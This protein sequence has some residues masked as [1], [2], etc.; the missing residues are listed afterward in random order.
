MLFHPIE[1][2]VYSRNL[3]ENCRARY[4]NTLLENSIVGGCARGSGYSKKSVWC[5]TSVATTPL[6][7]DE[8]AADFLSRH[9]YDVESAKL[10][11][12]ARCN[13]AKGEPINRMHVLLLCCVCCAVPYLADGNDRPPSVRCAVL[14]DHCWTTVGP[15][16]E[17]PMLLR[18]QGLDLCLFSTSA[19]YSE[20]CV[21]YTLYDISFVSI[22][23]IIISNSRTGWG[24]SAS[25]GLLLSAGASIGCE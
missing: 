2:L 20:F 24:T 22:I 6:E 25:L 21:E 5:D 23:S 10:E 11:L 4:E 1:F 7:S 14:K 15:Y 8:A 9:Q 12:F 19:W 17:C 13:A 3:V 18:V 16:T